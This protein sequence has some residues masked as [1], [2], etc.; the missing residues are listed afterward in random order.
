MPKVPGIWHHEDWTVVVKTNS[1][2]RASSQIVEKLRLMSWADTH[3]TPRPN[4]R[5]IRK[6]CELICSMAFNSDIKTP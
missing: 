1:G 5:Y 4:A 3:V 6:I 2:T